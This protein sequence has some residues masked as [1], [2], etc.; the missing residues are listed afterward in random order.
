MRTWRPLLVASLAVFGA[1]R[2]WLA[3]RSPEDV[4]RARLEA[5]AEG[6]NATRLGPCMEVFADRYIDETSGFVRDDVKT[7]VV[8]AFFTQVDP[9]SKDFLWRAAVED[10]EVE[11][12]GERARARFTVRLTERASGGTRDVWVFRVDGELGRG[13]GPWRLE[14]T[15]FV[16]RGGD[17]PR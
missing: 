17:L 12:D 9:A 13:E 8:N 16:T 10:V 1:S 15:S 3:L 11:V 6:F 7:A 4:V 5:A 14:R 2:L